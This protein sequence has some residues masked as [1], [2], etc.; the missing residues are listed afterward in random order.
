MKTTLI[1][2]SILAGLMIG[3]S[4]FHRTT[5]ELCQDLQDELKIGSAFAQE[6]NWASATQTFEQMQRNWENGSKSLAVFTHHDLLDNIK[7]SLARIISASQSNDIR[8]LRLETA[9]FLEELRDLQQADRLEIGN[10]F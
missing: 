6:E 7:I 2:F 9:T 8:T 4:Y 1:A 5:D 3:G 10:V